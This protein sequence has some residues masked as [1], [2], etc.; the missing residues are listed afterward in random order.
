MDSL[1]AGTPYPHTELSANNDH[2]HNTTNEFVN[3]FTSAIDQLA[4]RDGVGPFWPLREFW[5]DEVKSRRRKI[6]KFLDPIIADEIARQKRNGGKDNEEERDTLLSSIVQQTAGKLYV[7]GYM[8]LIIF[9]YQ[10]DSG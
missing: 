3:L 5:R 2:G 8:M 1:S 4:D 7:L 10:H 6:D 9:R